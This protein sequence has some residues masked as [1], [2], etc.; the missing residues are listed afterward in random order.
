MIPDFQLQVIFSDDLTENNEFDR[1]LINYDKGEVA[2]RKD[3]CFLRVLG[4]KHLPPPYFI[5]ICYHL[6]KVHREP[7]GLPSRGISRIHPIPFS[8]VCLGRQDIQPGQE[9]SASRL[10]VNKQKESRSES[11]L[12]WFRFWLRLE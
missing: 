12:P 1:E 5:P 6:Q 10:T 2:L 4:E 3:F 8:L 9:E 11:E 7:E